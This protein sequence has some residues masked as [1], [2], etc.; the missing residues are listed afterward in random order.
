M[1]PAI[2]F[3]RLMNILSLDV[4]LGAVCCAAW[5]ANHLN[6]QLRIY[7]LICLGLTVW[8]IYTTDHLMDALKMKTDASTARHRFHQKHFKLL[9]IALLIAG[10]IDL[11]LLFS[12]R[13]QVLYAGFVLSGIVIIYLLLNRWLNFLKEFVVAIVY[14]G[15]VLLPAISLK[16]DVLA[17]ADWI[18]IAILFFTALINL[19][20]FS[21]YETESDKQDGYNSFSIKFGTEFTRKLVTGLFIIQVLLLIVQGIISGELLPVLLLFVMNGTLFILFKSPENFK[22]VEKYR[23]WGDAI[24]LLP[25]LFLLFG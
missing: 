22:K 7:A 16:S 12:I 18:L 20:I 1:N 8:I 10:V 21:W 15:G 17:F 23:L 9:V 14:C 5:F 11:S 2:R 24:F 19:L 4:A 6:V 25:G 13:V 3:Y